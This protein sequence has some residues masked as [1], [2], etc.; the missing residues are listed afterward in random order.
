MGGRFIRPIDIRTSNEP[1]CHGHGFEW[2]CLERSVVPT[3]SRGH[4]TYGLNIRIA[5]TVINK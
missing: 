3:P 1:G 2:P 4:C 5:S